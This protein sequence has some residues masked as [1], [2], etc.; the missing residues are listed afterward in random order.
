M[1][2]STI[3]GL[4]IGLGAFYLVM[5]YGG[6]TGLLFNPV[7]AVLVF[8]GTLASA[9][10]S[11]PYGIIKSAFGAVWKVIFPPRNNQPSKGFIEKIVTLAEIAKRDGVSKLSEEIEKI[12]EPFLK[13]GIQLVV[14]TLP[15]E[16]IKDFL[17]NELLALKKKHDE[18]SNLFYIMGSYAPMFGLLG[19]LIGVIQVLRNI[20]EPKTMASALAIAVTT[21]LYG[22]LASNFIFTPIGGKLRVYSEK[23]MLQKKMVIEGVLDI[24]KGEVPIIVRR[25]LESYL[26]GKEKK[27]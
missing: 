24:Q 21:T 13:T 11:Y 9:L 14:D 15:P 4:A 17:E 20:T 25:K 7:A 16:L 23:E 8:G 18:V 6:L 10:I 22:I 12:D 2:F 5:D 1:D 26:L 27:I 3:I 19:T